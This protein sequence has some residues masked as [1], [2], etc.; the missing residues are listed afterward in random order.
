MSKATLFWIMYGGGLAGMMMHFLK[1]KVKGQS[2]EDVWQYFRENFKGTLTAILSTGFAVA[3]LWATA[4]PGNP[5]PSIL[6]SVPLGF[7]FDSVFTS[8]SRG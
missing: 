1:L 7:A 6:A 3:G 4:D 2:A 5:I 8:G